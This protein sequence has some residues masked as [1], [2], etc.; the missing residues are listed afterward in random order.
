[1]DDKPQTIDLDAIE[2]DI[3]FHAAELNRLRGVLRLARRIQAKWPEPLFR[4]LGRKLDKGNSYRPKSYSS[5]RP[6]KRRRGRPF[7]DNRSYSTLHKFID[8]Q[9]SEFTSRDLWEAVGLETDKLE[10]FSAMRRLKK[11][12]AFEIIERPVGRK[13]G[14][15][16]KAN[17]GDTK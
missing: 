3:A 4:N 15:Y 8:A 7:E 2:K 1:M 5:P 10:F 9:Q 6:A 13:L 14:K 11:E 12:N 17:G 16:R